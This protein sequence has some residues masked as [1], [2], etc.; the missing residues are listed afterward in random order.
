MAGGFGNIDDYKTTNDLSLPSFTEFTSSL[1]MGVD[2]YG[3]RRRQTPSTVQSEGEGYGFGLP[4]LSRSSQHVP[5]I[6]GY[7]PA[8]HPEHASPVSHLGCNEGHAPEHACLLS[9]L[10]CNEGHAPEHACLLSHLGCNEGHAPE[11]ASPFS[12]L[13]CNEGHAPEHASPFS[14]LGRNEGHAPEHASPF[15]HLGRNEGH[16]P[17][18]ASPFSHLGCNE[19]HAPEHASPFSHLGCNEGHAPEHASPFSHHCTLGLGH[20]DRG[21]LANNPFFSGRTHYP[22]YTESQ[23]PGQPGTENQQYVQGRYT[24]TLQTP[25]G[26]YTDTLQTFE[27][28]LCMKPVDQPDCPD[29]RVLQPHGSRSRHVTSDWTVGRDVAH[30]FW[31]KELCSLFDAIPSEPEV[32]QTSTSSQL[33]N[34]NNDADGYNNNTPCAR[35]DYTDTS[36]S[37]SGG[38]TPGYSSHGSYS[39]SYGSH[40]GYTGGY[41]SYGDYT[42]GYGSHGGYSEGTYTLNSSSETVSNY[43]EANNRDLPST[44]STDM[45]YAWYDYKPPLMTS[46]FCLDSDLESCGVTS[47]TDHG[48]D[49]LL[50]LPS[51]SNEKASFDH[52]SST[53]EST[54]ESESTRLENDEFDVKDKFIIPKESRRA[55]DEPRRPK[56]SF[57][58]FSVENR[59]RISREHPLMDNR[60]VS[61]I[62]GG[63]WKTL[64]P[65][66]KKPY[67]MEFSK[68]MEA[69]KLEN[70]DWQY[71]PTNRL[72]ADLV[73]PMPRRLRPRNCL[74]KKVV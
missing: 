26:I 31:T 33:D 52:V 12:H 22:A 64:T 43:G 74:K 49:P 55:A 44:S 45:S 34:Y 18:H 8:R 24:E 11:H 71:V 1:R 47:T 10:G 4:H 69:I 16:A 17:E 36:Y 5:G 13:G 21:G 68:D 40:G 30:E 73:E 61:K 19:G 72:A 46:E 28:P 35:S 51:L 67:E 66:Q 60:E 6:L 39:A 62:L 29:S 3:I 25:A 15:S 57:I 65:E 50:K 70:P 42:A 27:H 38:Y 56:N 59:R 14:H 41:G 53:S 9:H 32:L 48:H 37:S 7:R 63:L 20:T 54:T 23:R 58:R 2:C